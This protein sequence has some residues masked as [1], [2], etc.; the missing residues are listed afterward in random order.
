[1][2]LA[3]FFSV[4]FSIHLTNTIVY[5][6]LGEVTVVSGVPCE[7]LKVLWHLVITDHWAQPKKTQLLKQLTKTFQKLKVI[8]GST[9]IFTS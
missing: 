8:E 4:L 2:F 3:V 5:P 9:L 1:M 7:I 6:G